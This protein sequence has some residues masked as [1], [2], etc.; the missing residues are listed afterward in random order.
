MFTYFAATAIGSL[1]LYCSDYL[2]SSR[3]RLASLLL[4]I[5]S[6]S[7]FCFVA[8]FRN[9]EVGTDVLVYGQSAYNVAKTSSVGQMLS[10]PLFRGWGIL[11][12]IFTWVTAR[13][14]GS[15]SGYLFAIQLLITL[16]IY[17]AIWRLNRHFAYIGVALFG[18]FFFPISLNMMRQSA[19]MAFIVLMMGALLRQNWRESLAWLVVASLLHQS[20]LICIVLLFIVP[21]IKKF[22]AATIAL[23]F[24][25]LVTLY[26]AYPLVIECI[27]GSDGYGAYLTGSY[28]EMSGGRR[29]NLELTAAFLCLTIYLIFFRRGLSA[30]LTFSILLCFFL[31]GIFGIWLSVYS[32]YL[33]RIGLYFLTASMLLIPYGIGLLNGSKVRIGF[34][35]IAIAIF[36]IIHVDYFIL[37]GAHQVVPYTSVI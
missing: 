12:V 22:S 35:L 2:L 32:Y 1:L 4:F 14:V 20:A 13:T 3:R 29:L 26:V 36:A 31:I 33:Y 27:S 10:V 25:L 37:I 34:E 15:L 30:D 24:L 9:L 19:A 28:S 23:L 16:P 17:I 7:I 11:Y 6:V 8:A 18:L 21:C 5:A